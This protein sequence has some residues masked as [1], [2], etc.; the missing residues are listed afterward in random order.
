MKKMRVHRTMAEQCVWC[1][2]MLA[3]N[4]LLLKHILEK[5]A[6]STKSATVSSVDGAGPSR[7]VIPLRARTAPTSRKSPPGALPLQ[8]AAAAPSLPKTSKNHLCCGVC[9]KQYKH[10]RSLVRHHYESHGE[11]KHGCQQCSKLFKSKRTLKQHI[12]L[13]HKKS[14][15]RKKGHRCLKCVRVFK[16]LK[17]LYVHKRD[18][19]P[20][21]Y[22]RYVCPSCFKRFRTPSMWQWHLRVCKDQ[23]NKQMR[24]HELKKK[25]LYKSRGG[26]TQSN[27]SV[28]EQTETEWETE[29]A[30]GGDARVHTLYVSDSYD[31][32]LTLLKHKEKMLDILLGDIKD[33]RRMKWYLAAHIHCHSTEDGKE[34]NDPITKY[35]KCSP[36]ISLGQYDLESKLEKAILACVNSYDTSQVEGS[37]LLFEKV[38]LVELRVAKYSP[39][40][41]SSF[42]PLPAWLKIPAKGLI[43]IQ[44]YNDNKCFLWSCLAG[45]ALPRVHP[46]RLS[47]Y[48]N[49]EKELCMKNIKYP[50][51]LND[52]SKFETQNKGISV[53]V[54]GLE[55]ESAIVPLRVTPKLRNRHINLLL[56][57]EGDEYHYVLIKNISRFLSHLTTRRKRL[58]WCE[59]CLTP[60][61]KKEKHLEHRERCIEHDAQAIKMPAP[62]DST[63]KF[64]EHYARMRHDYVIY[65]D[66][67]AVLE[68]YDTALHDPSHSRTTKINKHVAC[69]Y[70]YV[71]IGADGS[72]VKAPVVERGPDVIRKLL[73][74]LRKEQG[75]INKLRGEVYP[76]DMTEESIKRFAEATHCYMCGDRVPREGV[77]KV[78]DHDWSKEKDNF[79]GAACNA[80]CNLNLKRREYI[81]VIMHNLSG[82][83]AH[84]IISEI[85]Q[86][87][88]GSDLTAIPRTKEKYVSFTWGKLRFL[89]S[90]GFLSSSLD[91]LVKDLSADDMN[92]INFMFPDE[93]KRKLVAQKGA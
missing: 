91:T 9:K 43:N 1:G 87:T 46:E 93:E 60:R 12:L 29:T 4:L 23:K 70:S 77:V 69:G 33:L 20:P 72:M 55:E 2:E 86:L 19:H 50:V 41:G 75:E 31:V 56:L 40:R 88:D 71:I 42:L 18:A 57:Q 92:C 30:I 15:V 8:T 28:L 34:K 13:K 36:V 54:F 35:L 65:C 7:T 47:H 38:Y 81:P 62:K 76:I 3:G 32:Q 52:I 90:Y 64:T 10:K 79:R 51:K 49:R 37:H 59:N 67:E 17:E 58:Y 66:I 45:V 82:Y 73:L 16:S 5:H 26:Q 6:P 14:V 78:R 22:D 24:F 48:K 27:D 89:D 68:P 11:K 39:F 61:D 21:R 80:P 74:S 83:D 84:H 63:M 53:S 44:N 25:R 85:G